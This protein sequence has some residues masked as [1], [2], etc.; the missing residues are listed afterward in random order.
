M[1]NDANPDR[2]NVTQSYSPNCPEAIDPGQ[3]GSHHPDAATQTLHKIRRLSAPFYGA[4]RSAAS[5]TAFV[6]RAEPGPSQ[7]GIPQSRAPTAGSSF[8]G[9]GIFLRP[10]R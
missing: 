5:T 6:L 1:V 2:S 8:A 9:Y 10:R 7:G 4:H 3:F